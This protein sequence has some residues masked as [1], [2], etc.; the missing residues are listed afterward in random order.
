MKWLTARALQVSS[1]TDKDLTSIHC[2]EDQRRYCLSNSVIQD[3]TRS[4]TIKESYQIPA[5][6]DVLAVWNVQCESLIRNVVDKKLELAV[7]GGKDPHDV[8][9]FDWAIY[10]ACHDGSLTFKP[11][12]AEKENRKISK[13]SESLLAGLLL[14]AA[15]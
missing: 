11:Y 3:L 7:E 12:G 1:L 6:D 5:K 8:H 14:L 15:S 2:L 4:S 13:F 10:K 9:E